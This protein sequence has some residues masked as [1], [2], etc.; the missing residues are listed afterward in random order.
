M[1]V[2]CDETRN[3][4]SNFFERTRWLWTEKLTIVAITETVIMQINCD[5][6]SGPIYNK[7]LSFTYYKSGERLGKVNLASMIGKISGLKSEKIVSER[8]LVQALTSHLRWNSILPRWQF[9]LTNSQVELCPKV[10]LETVSRR[11]MK[12]QAPAMPE[13]ITTLNFN[14]AFWQKLVTATVTLI[15]LV[16]T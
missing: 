14:V 6:E 15:W 16:L 7:W 10:G 13:L 11:V 3:V 8:S 12:K 4:M 1:Q 9:V 5:T 2:Y